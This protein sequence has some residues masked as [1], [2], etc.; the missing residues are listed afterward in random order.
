LASVVSIILANGTGTSHDRENEHIPSLDV[1]LAL[2]AYTAAHSTP[3]VIGTWPH[4]PLQLCSLQLTHDSHWM[5]VLRC[6]A[7]SDCF[8]PPWSN[9]LVQ[10]RRGHA[11]SDLPYG[12]RKYPTLNIAPW[13]DEFNESWTGFV[14]CCN[15]TTSSACTACVHKTCMPKRPRSCWRSNRKST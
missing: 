1:D 6:R 12:A 3:L 7:V 11:M 4:C 10:R 14:Y 5:P 15:G 13:S 2:G 8:S 9:S